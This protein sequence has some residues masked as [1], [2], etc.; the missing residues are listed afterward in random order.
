MK[1]LKD[2]KAITYY[3][4]LTRTGADFRILACRIG[5]KDCK[6]D[7]KP[8]ALY[9]GEITKGSSRIIQIQVTARS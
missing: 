2:L 1:H 4:F 5:D 6:R 8:V 9:D 3:E 7:W